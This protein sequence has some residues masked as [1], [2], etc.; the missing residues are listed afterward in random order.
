M[1]IHRI[2]CLTISALLLLSSH[3][4]AQVRP[5]VQSTAERDQIRFN[6]EMMEAF[7]GLTR[8][9]SAAMGRGDIRAAAALYTD[10]AVMIA[11]PGQMAS[12]RR[13]I[14]QALVEMSSRWRNLR[15]GLLDFEASGRLMYGLGTYVYE[16]GVGAATSTVTGTYVLVLH[17]GGRSLRIRSQTFHP[18]ARAPESDASAAGDRSRA[19]ETQLLIPG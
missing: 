7:Q 17:R 8:N 13:D 15:I 3:L 14:E 2:F 16:E 1:R 19:T 18:P 5:I 12:G 6:A 11:E 10:N 9:W 4:G